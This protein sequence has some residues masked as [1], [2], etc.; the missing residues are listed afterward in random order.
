MKQLLLFTLFLF[1]TS[2]GF[3]QEEE[4]K[5]PKNFDLS[6]YGIFRAHLA[7][8]AGE[9]EVQDATPRVGFLFDYHFG[10]NNKYTIFFGGEFAINLIDNQLDFNA[11][12][13]TND[14][15]FAI[16]DFE[17]KKST[18]STRLGFVGVNFA[19]YGSL[20]LGKLNSV[21]KSIAG[22]GDIFNVMSG[23]AAY[24][25]APTNTDGGE[26]GTGRAE[27]ALIYQNSFWR[28][29]IG[30]QTQMRASGGDN[31]F[32]SY[33]ASLRFHFT[34]YLSIGT[35]YNKAKLGPKFLD[36]DNLHGLEGDAE[37][38]TAGI[39]YHKGSL[40][41]SAVYAQQ[42]NGDFT[43]TI[44]RVPDAPENELVTII[45]PGKGYEL[46]GSYFFLKSKLKIMIGFNYKDP[47]I[48]TPF[49]PENF[50]TRMYLIGAQ[51][52]FIKFAS[53]Y[54]E[55][56]FE[57]SINALNFTPPNVFMIG[58]RLDFDKTWS[59]NIEL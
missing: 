6:I 58:L 7:T 32:D 5:I 21:Y 18:F 41:L 36:L 40:F 55:Y 39:V 50:R 12:P 1:F 17:D 11:D 26:T 8:F 44:I 15:G 22:T 35:S 34:D 38:F 14:S 33:S 13:N 19:E 28:F 3:S 23:Q 29:D 49:L 51:Y 54:S 31:F 30:L 59:K 52:Q 20:T 16:L 56:K 4:N 37:Y 47:E 24:V 10:K 45:Y 43:N 57:D 25:Y 42:K 46:V 48:K 53:V 9:A 27:S 2:S